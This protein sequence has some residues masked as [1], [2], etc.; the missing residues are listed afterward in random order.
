MEKKNRRFW[1]FTIILIL[2]V[3]FG[4]IFSNIISSLIQARGLYLLMILVFIFV[5]TL[6]LV[7]K[8]WI[9]SQSSG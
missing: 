9:F 3:V 4:V 8:K 6:D 2:F 7:V 5:V 1:L